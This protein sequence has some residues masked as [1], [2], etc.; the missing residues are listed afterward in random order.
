M[1]RLVLLWF[2]SAFALMVVTQIVPG[3]HID[4]GWSALKAAFIIAL[5]NGTIGLFVAIATLPLSILTLG[6]FLIIVNALMLQLSAWIVEGFAIDG[7]WWAVAGSI[8]LSATNMLL[9]WLLVPKTRRPPE[10]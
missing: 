1:R 4:D 10:T 2:I 5:V 9:R 3:F 8:V 7:F 6:L